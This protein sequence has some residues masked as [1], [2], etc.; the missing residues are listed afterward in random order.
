MTGMRSGFATP[1]NRAV[2]SRT[3]VLVGLGWLL[4]ATAL[5]AASVLRPSAGAA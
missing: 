4:T 1:H 2:G 3:V 5:G